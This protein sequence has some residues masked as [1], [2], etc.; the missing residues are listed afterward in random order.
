M[1]KTVQ[2][3]YIAIF[4]AA[5]LLPVPLFKAIKPYIDEQLRKQRAH[6]AAGAAAERGEYQQLSFGLRQLDV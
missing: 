2:A 5:I 4:T 1:R 3:F 6:A